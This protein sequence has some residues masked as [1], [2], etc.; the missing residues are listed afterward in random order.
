[1]KAIDVQ[2]MMNN[3]L[4]A[5]N[6]NYKKAFR[7]Y[8]RMNKLRSKEGLPYLSMPNLENRIADM[9]KRKKA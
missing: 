8:V 3:A 5:K 1:M 9:A 6:V 2:K 4:A 7:L